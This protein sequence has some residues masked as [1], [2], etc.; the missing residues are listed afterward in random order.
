VSVAPEIWTIRP[1]TDADADAISDVL[2]EAGAKAWAYLGEE[3]V[4]TA[5]RGVHQP[6]D[7]VAVDEHGEVFAFVAWDASTGEVT[8]LFTHPRGWGYG[9]GQALLERA[10]TTLHAAGREQAWLWTEERN[11]AVGF[12]EHA[13]FR[14]EGEPRVRDWHGAQLREPRFARD[15]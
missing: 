3:R 7:L 1:A 5:N 6:A 8:R 12:Y 9:A 14:R 10:C 15:L 13:G 2:L 11:D 4:R